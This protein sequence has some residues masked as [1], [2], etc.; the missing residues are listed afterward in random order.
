MT[1]L[2][3]QCGKFVPGPQGSEEEE[4]DN[5]DPPFPISHFMKR[6]DTGCGN[7]QGQIGQMG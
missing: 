5:D 6:M 2:K 7:L 4:D 3:K 1:N